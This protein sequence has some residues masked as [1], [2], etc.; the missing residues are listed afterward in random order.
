MSGGTTPTTHPL[1]P[2]TAAGGIAYLKALASPLPVMRFCPTGGIDADNAPAYLALD[3]VVCVGGSWVTP[4]D[5]LATGDWA[6]VEE[7][8]RKASRLGAN[9]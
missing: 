3:N 6:R 4:K 1:D 9:R 5:A 7:L 2:V 8:A